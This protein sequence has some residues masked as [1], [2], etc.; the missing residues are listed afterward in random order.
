MS[1]Y[2]IYYRTNHPVLSIVFYD[3][4]KIMFIL[5]NNNM[6]KIC[7]FK[8]ECDHYAVL[9]QKAAEKYNNTEIAKTEKG[10][11]YFKNIP[12]L[13]FSVSHT[14]GLTVIALG[15]CEVGIDAEKLRKADLRITRRFLK[16]EIDY[17]TEKDSDRRFFEIWTK[18]EAYLKH[19]GTGLSGGFDS[20]NV[21]KLP[22]K[23]VVFEDYIISVYSQKEY[24]IE[25]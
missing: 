18:K 16:E 21:L 23:T 1:Y 12:D 25:K 17:I 3:I 13:F 14:D 9:H 24:E 7:I 2:H 15:D 5:Y 20:V 6:N 19:K 4:A 11:P 8:G 10:K 22:I